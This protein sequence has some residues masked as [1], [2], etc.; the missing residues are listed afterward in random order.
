MARDIDDLLFVLLQARNRTDPAREDEFRCFLARLGARAE[1]VRQ[2]DILTERLDDSMMRDAD[3]L[4]VGGSGEYSVLDDHPPIRRF[5]SYLAEFSSSGVPVFAS[6]FGFQALA[7][8]LGGEVIHDDDHA[9]VGT[10]ELR[11]TE[12]GAEDELFGSFPRQF[13]AQLGHKDR[14]AR[15]PDGMQSL[16]ESEL[17]PTQAFRL[18]GLPVYATQFHAELD[19]RAN[20]ERFRGYMDTYGRLFGEREAIRKLLGHT[21]S[22][23][24]NDLVRRFVEHFAL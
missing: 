23:E 12:A 20:K 24:A 11:L 22:P 17:C 14:V 5:G 18:P 10:Y 8:A 2:V 15:L 4:L 6:C 3:V 9:E 16:A 19:W 7:L 1:Q 13:K 21:P